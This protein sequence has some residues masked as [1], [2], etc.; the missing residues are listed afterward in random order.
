M[1]FPVLKLQIFTA[2]MDSRPLIT[3]GEPILCNSN[4]LKLPFKQFSPDF[5]QKTRQILGANGLEFS[6]LPQ[7]LFTKD[8]IIFH[9]CHSQVVA[10]V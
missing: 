1:K 6:L 9:H 2:E 3:L 8:K 7:K 5:G 10:V 4:H